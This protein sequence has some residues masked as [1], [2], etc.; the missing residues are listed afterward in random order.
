MLRKRPIM[1]LAALVVTACAAISAPSASAGVYSVNTCT[2][3]GTGSYDDWSFDETAGTAGGTPYFYTAI[4]CWTSGIYKRFEVNAVAAGAASASTFHAPADTWI[5][6]A[7]VYQWAEPRS[8]GAYDTV[9]AEL[10]DG[11]RRMVGTAIAT[12]GSNLRDAT[13]NMPSSGA[14]AVR[15]RAELGCQSG[16]N[17]S[18]TTNGLYGN[19][20][21]ISGAVVHLVDPSLPVIAT[22]SGPG[23]AAAPADGVWNID[24]GASDRGSG[25]YEV[26]FLVDGIQYTMNRSSC[27]GG[28]ARPCPLSSSGSFALDTTRLSEGEHSV[29][30]VAVDYSGNVTPAGDKQLTVTVRRAPQ[31]STTAPVSTTDPSANGGGSPA[32]GDQLSGNAGGWTGSGLTYAYQWMRCDSA[33]QACVAIPGATN[34]IYKAT[35]DDIGH[36]LSFCVTATNSGGSATSCSVP[37]SAVV[38]SHP[39]AA[40]TADLPGTVTTPAASPGAGATSADRGHPNGSPAA[41]KVVLTALINNRFSSQ[42]VKFGKNAPI[43]GRLV[44]PDGAPI[45]GATLSVQVQTSVPGASMADAAQVVTGPD[46]RFRYTAPAGPS[47]TVRFGYRS[48]SADRSFA[49]TTDVR[50]L[51]AAGVTM[52][53]K[54]KKV[55]N[56]HATVFTG[57]LLGG[58]VPRR[59]VVVD[60]QVFF[61]KQWRTFA[62]PRTNRAGVYRFKYRFMAGAATWKFRARVRVDTSYPYSLGYSAR[63]IKV[64][65]VR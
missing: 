34:T 58:P 16:G 25:V 33:G 12:A 9:Y 30:L 42:K 37:T 20:Y 64:K 43:S 19:E 49:D 4:R 11:T 22:V 38:G 3:S 61:R 56:R 36:T 50:L 63:A 32:V 10:D 31:A 60:L 41:D 2:Q 21:M 54:P 48:Y 57:R 47:R 26:R 18:G 7:D 8:P 51:V 55:R 59:G 53:A 65:V 27:S 40:T 5:Q 29:A 24:Y 14:H 1:L 6:S 13:Y 62:A 23:W 44:G 46:G 35:S 17:C 15:L 52:R 39:S 45:G 28:V